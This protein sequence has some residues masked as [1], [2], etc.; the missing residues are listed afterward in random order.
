MNN[1]ARR[2]SVIMPTFQREHLIERAIRSVFSQK[3]VADV[4]IELVI[5]DDGGTDK[6]ED[7][8]S[9]I[10][11]AAPH[12]LVYEKI[13]HV[14]QPGIVRN[15]GI[16]ISSGEFIGYCDSDDI[17]LPHHL[18]T[19]LRQFALHPEIVM[20]ETWWSFQRRE[21]SFNRWKLEYD[22]AAT[23][24][25]TTT[26]NSRLHRRSILNSTGMFGELRWGEDIDLW[27]RIGFKGPVRRVKIPTTAHSYTYGG[28]NITFQHVPELARAYNANV[29][30]AADTV[31]GG[32]AQQFFRTA[33]VEEEWYAFAY[34]EAAEAV[35][36]GRYPS[37]Q[38]QYELVG[39]E[40][41]RI[42]RAPVFD[43]AYYLER[44]PDV[45]QAIVE[46]SFA[47]AEEH[48]RA[49]G[50]LEKRIPSA[51]LLDET[52]YLAKYPDVADAVR[53][54]DFENGLSHYV[55]FG[56]KENR[57]PNAKHQPFE[58]KS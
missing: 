39:M 33:T 55:D 1:A 4:E 34:P 48:Y 21:R 35:R 29:Q 57:T 41:S 32:A 36:E 30:T 42:A 18:A 44:Y 23:D 15:H 52:W 38:R 50:F 5:V 40:Q 10:E 14:G 46:G 19:C 25:R 22:A 13:E 11:V 43:A 58:F 56:F 7:V 6:T 37:L 49:A 8:V 47:S 53:A 45:A 24:G 12:R 2:V 31:D 51:P 54:G 20:V 27:T 28:D 16:R 9:T 17:W 3:G 26:T